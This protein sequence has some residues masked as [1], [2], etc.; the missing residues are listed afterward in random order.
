MDV[1]VLGVHPG[2]PV[3][4]VNCSREGCIFSQLFFLVLILILKVYE[5]E[6]FF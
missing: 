6:T 5:I 3:T 2:A 1:G 4:M